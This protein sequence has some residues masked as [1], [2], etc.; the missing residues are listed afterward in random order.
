LREAADRYGWQ[1]DKMAAT[2]GE[3]YVLLLAVERDSFD[4]LNKGY[5]AVFKQELIPIG[6]IVSGIPM[7]GWRRDGVV[8][9][10]DWKGFEHF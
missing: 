9:S 3:D 2:G 5:K 6:E 7:I 10:L 8:Q 4:E 1:V